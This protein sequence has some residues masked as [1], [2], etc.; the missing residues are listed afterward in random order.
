MPFVISLII[1][2]TYARGCR[3]IRRQLKE[4]VLLG[5]NT[6]SV[7]G[8]QNIQAKR[9]IRCTQSVAKR[10]SQNKTFE[11]SIASFPRNW[12]ANKSAMFA[13]RVHS[14][15]IHHGDVLKI[16]LHNFLKH[17]LSFIR[18]PTTVTTKP[19]PSRQNRKPHGKIKN[20]TAKTKYLTTIQN[21]KPHG[22][23]KDLTAKPNTS[24]QKPNT[25]R[26]KQIS[27]AKPKLFC[28]CCEV[29]GF[30]ERFLVLP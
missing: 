30:A 20:L 17:S 24:Q 1:L 16:D 14:C 25:S 8:K 5:T 12:T 26:Q 19:K 23:T 7:M 15:W 21:Q 10:R 3:C 18:W 2:H 22:K 27:T 4:T 29:F 28:I 6:W 11:A 9:S 13:F